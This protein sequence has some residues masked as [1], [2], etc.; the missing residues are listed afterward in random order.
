MRTCSPLMSQR[1][2]SPLLAFGRAVSA[3]GLK[4]KR[5][6]A[7]WLAFI[8]PFTIALL[9]F[10]LFYQRG[11][12]TALGDANPWMILGQQTLI[13]WAILMQPLFITLETALIAGLDHTGD[14]WKHLFALALPRWAVYAAKQVMGMAIIGLSMIALDG[15]GLLVGVMLR[16]LKPEYGFD[17]PIPVLRLL[18]FTLLTYLGSWLI[19][20]IHTWIGN[21]WRSFVVA[22]SVGV[23][24]TVVAVMVINSEWNGLYP[25]TMPAMIANNFIEE[26][27]AFDLVLIGSIGGILMAIAGGLEF[28]R[29][30]VL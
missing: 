19:L 6:L 21:R 13:F 10:I 15:F 3:E 8:A 28:I 9:Q 20:S 18:W 25:W 22:M 4:L 23:V 29:R 1:R 12:S 7:F 30:D 5:T 11:I 26:N 14:H 24:M 27:P 17:Q 16:L 2:L